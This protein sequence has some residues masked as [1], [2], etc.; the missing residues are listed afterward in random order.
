MRIGRPRL[1]F[2]TKVVLLAVVLAAASQL[3]IL[4]PLAH[5]LGQRQLSEAD[6][7]LARAAVLYD[8]Y[9]SHRGQ[10]LSAAGAVLASDYRLHS[11]LTVADSDAID[12]LLRE[13]ASRS[14]AG[15]TA[16]HGTAVLAGLTN[17]VAALGVLA[18]LVTAA[19]AACLAGTVTRPIRRL[20]AAAR[21][22]A[23]GVYGQPLTVR[24]EDEFAEL[25]YGFN[26]MQDAI[27][28]REQHIVHMAHHDSLSGLPTRE[29]IVSQMR[30]AL[31]TV[32]RL[33]V[34]NFVLHRFDEL[35]ASLGHNTADQLIRLVAGRLR[36]RLEDGQILGHLN[37]QEFIFVL[38]GADQNAA[39]ALVL[40]I[41]SML[42][43]GLA[44]GNANIA[45]QIRAGISHCPEHGNDASKLLS[46]AGVARGKARHHQGSCGFY[47]PGQEE[48]PRQLI[49]IVGDFPRALLNG[50]LWVEYQP[51]V[52]C[53]SGE[54]V[55][56]EALVRWQHPT[57]GRLPPDEFV[58][59]I[60]QTGGIS[61][62]TRW[63]LAEATRTLAGWHAAGLEI[64][65]SVNVSADD[66]IDNELPAWLV[67]LCA[68]QGV[69]PEWLTL[70]I[71]ESAIMHDVESSLAVI[72][73]LRSH[74]FRIAIDDFGTGHSALAQLKRLPVD[75]LKIDKSFVT[76][77]G[78]SRD[79]A[80]VR[81]AIDLAQ[82]FGLTAVAEGVEDEACRVR[83]VRLGCEIAQGYLFSR[84]L[85]ARE[86]PVWARAWQAGAGADIVSLVEV[87]NTRRRASR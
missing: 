66:L 14:W 5:E 63:V 64:S 15:D 43:S 41:Q 73:S 56:A 25:A 86:F 61:Q 1:N 48:R 3:A 52:V 10:Q 36:D 37:R 71:T 83:L 34:V 26:A 47:E 19:V 70:E 74:G 11:A 68:R 12:S 80:V 32:E 28:S 20:V 77:I 54:L 16:T 2:R 59:A 8:E 72:A 81:S 50:E 82:Q 62:L 85:P 18:L 57:L 13:L 58:A 35:A 6:A 79:E 67:E 38:P 49:R 75:E 30:D 17:R 46:C 55:G 42:R 23:D 45:M 53:D 87:P 7:R 33:A 51:K 22:M 27:A 60:E 39:E 84:A 9:L 21:R 69:E 31:A 24:S 40:E 65:L 44:V 4:V 29:I 78:D 76:N